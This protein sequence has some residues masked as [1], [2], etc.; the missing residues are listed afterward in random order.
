MTKA[1]WKFPESPVSRHDEAA[2]VRCGRCVLAGAPRHAVQLARRVASR[3]A[4][5]GPRAHGAQHAPR[6]GGTCFTASPRATYSQHPQS[7]GDRGRAEVLAPQD[8]EEAPRR[9]SVSALNQGTATHVP[10]SEQRPHVLDSLDPKSVFQSL[11]GHVPA[12]HSK[13]RA[14]KIKD[15]DVRLLTRSMHSECQRHTGLQASLTWSP[16][17]SQPPRAWPPSAVFPWQMDQCQLL[18]HS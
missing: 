9:S 13:H 12:G 2:R 1:T 3:A 5:S 11:S 7:R 16:L 15:C 17:R 18:N 8:P 14:E 10:P 6:T 4:V